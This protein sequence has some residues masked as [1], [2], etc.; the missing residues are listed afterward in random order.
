MTSAMIEFQYVEIQYIFYVLISFAIQIPLH[1]Q[2]HSFSTTTS[3]SFYQNGKPISVATLWLFDVCN[4]FI[5]PGTIG[6]L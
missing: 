4:S 3:R 6:I 2:Q 1:F 5:S